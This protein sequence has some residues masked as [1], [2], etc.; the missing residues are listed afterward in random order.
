VPTIIKSGD[1]WA[2]IPDKCEIEMDIQYLPADRDEKGYGSKVKKEIEDHLS[3]SCQADTW[4]A[5][6]PARIEWIMDLPPMEVERNHPLVRNVASAAE[7]VSVKPQIS[8]LDS[9]DDGAHLM[10]LARIPSISIGPGPT[11]QAHVVDEFVLV[12]TTVRTAKVLCVATA[13]WCGISSLKG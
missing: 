2:T 9:W 8:A 6:H 11:E 1:F 10:N 4:L 7:A 5:R 12:E 3:R 13:D